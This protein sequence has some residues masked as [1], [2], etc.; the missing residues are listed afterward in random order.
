MHAAPA[1]TYPA[2]RPRLYT[3][4][5]VCLWMAVGGLLVA[6]GRLPQVSWGQLLAVAAAAVVA[7][8]IAWQSWRQCPVGRLSW[9]GLRWWWTGDGVAGSPS[10]EGHVQAVLDLQELLLV[11]FRPAQAGRTRWLWM[12]RVSAPHAWGL[13]RCAVMQPAWASEVANQGRVRP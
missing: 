13:L 6:F 9:D 10:E 11:R 4:A 5:F 3:A 8:G 7:C 12:Q 2:G 1:V